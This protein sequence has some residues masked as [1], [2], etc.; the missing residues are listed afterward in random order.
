MKVD[1]DRN[2]YRSNFI[3]TFPCNYSS[4]LAARAPEAAPTAPGARSTLAISLYIWHR[5]RMNCHGTDRATQ[6]TSTIAT[7][8]V[9]SVAARAVIPLHRRAFAAPVKTYSDLDPNKRQYT[10]SI[11]STFCSH[12][13]TQARLL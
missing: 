8:L 3:A 7:M 9:R 10:L 5:A 1:C 13:N 4:S 11:L 2:V 6:R 12:V